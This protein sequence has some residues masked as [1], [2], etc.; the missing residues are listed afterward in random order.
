MTWEIQLHRPLHAAGYYLNPHFHYSPEFK[1]GSE[2]K[3]GLYTCLQRM[4]PD[5]CERTLID[6][7][8]EA[9]KEAKG[10]FG[11][12]PA[13]LARKSKTPGN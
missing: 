1:A 9:F 8:L 7:Q 3:L 2:I 10:I 4:V 13:K 6:S 12:E 5:I 11:I